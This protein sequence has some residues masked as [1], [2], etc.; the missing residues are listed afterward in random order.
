MQILGVAALSVALGG[1][2][3]VSR[4]TTETIGGASTPPRAVKPR[5]PL[6]LSAP[7]QT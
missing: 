4:G 6:R 2:A 3:S 7:P 1:C 5:N